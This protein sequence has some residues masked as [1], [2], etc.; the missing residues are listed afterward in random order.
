MLC[1]DLG[2]HFRALKRSKSPAQKSFLV[3]KCGFFCIC[4]LTYKTL[5]FVTGPTFFPPSSIWKG[6]VTHVLLA[7]RDPRAQSNCRSRRDG[8]GK[9]L[10][11]AN[12]GQ[13]TNS[14]TEAFPAQLLTQLC[15]HRAS[16]RNSHCLSALS[17][18]GPTHPLTSGLL[19]GLSPISRLK[20]PPGAPKSPSYH[21]KPSQSPNDTSWNPKPSSQSP[22]ASSRSP[23]SPKPSSRSSPPPPGA[24]IPPPS[25][26]P[27]PSP[28][29]PDLPHPSAHPRSSCRQGALPRPRAPV[30][31]GAPLSPPDGRRG[32]GGGAA[33][34]RSGPRA[35]RQAAPSRAGRRS[36]GP[37]ESAPG[38]GEQYG[39]QPMDG[40]RECPAGTRAGC[41]AA[42]S[43]AAWAE[44][45]AG[46][47][48]AAGGPRAGRRPRLRALLRDSPG[49]ALTAPHALGDTR[50]LR[51]VCAPTDTNTARH[52]CTDTLA[53]TLVLD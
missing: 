33:G 43:G 26:S 5:E 46:A 49:R 19:T 1:G 41:C 7:E 40:G 17:S 20:L 3:G 45:T 35:R 47:E 2:C 32:G 44:G 37:A 38:L 4:L 30:A 11:N 12:R 51:D 34:R 39:R 9:L 23:W 31:A 18:P 6:V 28:H 52:S 42:D 13:N 36:R 16:P 53:L 24:P 14:S 50:G 21:P 15:H 48:G 10:P 27:N 25:N 22:N 8:D 29:S